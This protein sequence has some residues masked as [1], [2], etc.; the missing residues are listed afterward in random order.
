MK[1]STSRCRCTGQRSGSRSTSVMARRRGTAPDP[2]SPGV[3]GAVVAW[4]M[5][6]WSFSPLLRL[7]D[8]L[9]PYRSV[10]DG[11]W[12]I[13]YGTVNLGTCPALPPP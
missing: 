6:V 5:T 12:G 10:S 11:M 4:T 2:V 7:I 8:R 3:S 9:A 13:E 1:S